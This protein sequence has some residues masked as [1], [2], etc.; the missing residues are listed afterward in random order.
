MPV[1]QGLLTSAVLSASQPNL[2]LFRIKVGGFK[3]L[4]ASVSVAV[5]GFLP[6]T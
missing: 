2:K 4:T 6:S 3:P 1:Q 5:H